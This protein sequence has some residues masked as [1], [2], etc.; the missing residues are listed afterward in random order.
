MLG[1]V[2]HLCIRCPLKGPYRSLQE[3]EMA[4]KAEMA[5]VVPRH[6]IWELH[7]DKQEQTCR[8][9]DDMLISMHNAGAGTED[10]HVPADADTVAAQSRVKQERFPQA[11]LSGFTSDFRKAYKQDTLSPMQMLLM[12]IAVWCHSLMRTNYWIPR[13]QL[14]GSRVSP[15]NFH[16]CPSGHTE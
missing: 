4:H 7:G 12:V 10:T 13:T 14:F 15:V 11:G 5:Y 1:T 9:I 6:G 8:L 2:A 3:V 16:A